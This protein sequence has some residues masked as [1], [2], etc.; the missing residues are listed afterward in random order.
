MDL[1]V[2]SELDVAPFFQIVD[3][4]FQTLVLFQFLLHVLVTSRNLL[5]LL[6]LLNL[7]LHVVE[8][9]DILLDLSF[10]QLLFQLLLVDL[11]LGSS[12]FCAYLHQI[13]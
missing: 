1:S 9:A 11:S 2:V 6:Q 7:G 4:S 13:V 10:L 5:T 3:Y 8:L 12:A